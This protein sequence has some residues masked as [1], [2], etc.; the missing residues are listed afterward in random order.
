MALETFTVSLE[1]SVEVTFDPEIMMAL[2]DDSWREAFYRSITTPEDVAGHLA[3][4]HLRNGVEDV[5]RLDGFANQEPPLD[6]RFKMN[7]WVDV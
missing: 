4:N 2:V 3:Y 7:V 6:V 1:A 5:N